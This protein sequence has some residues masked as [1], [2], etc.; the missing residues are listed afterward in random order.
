[1]RRI[2]TGDTEADAMI[3]LPQTS[4]NIFQIITALISIRL[5]FVWL[6][7]WKTNNGV[8]PFA[9]YP[10]IIGSV[11][12]IFYSIILLSSVNETFPKSFTVISSILRLFSIS[13]LWIAG[14]V[15]RR[16]K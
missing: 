3:I 14:E 10:V 12:L 13:L 9:L 2:T 16:K 4:D 11:T 7:L 8:K 5:I 6:R 15:T 1:V